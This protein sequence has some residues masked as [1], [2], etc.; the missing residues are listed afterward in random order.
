MWFSNPTADPFFW[1]F[2]EVI[3]SVLGVAFV[4]LLV[5]EWRHLRELHHRELF[6]GLFT[7]IWIAPLYSL[8][9][10]SGRIP[11]LLLTCLTVFQGLREYA[12]L[13]D[14]PR[15]YRW[16]LIGMGV[17]APPAALHSPLDSYA[18][19]ISFS[20]CASSNA[21]CIF[22]SRNWSMSESRCWSACRR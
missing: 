11:V 4:V 19:G 7:W 10:L 8:A 3:G 15:I 16:L 22:M 2:I 18:P 1:P 5:L 13:V 12:R 6:R 17:L 21:G 14:L 9:I 20:R